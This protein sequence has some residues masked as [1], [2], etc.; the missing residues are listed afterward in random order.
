MEKAK[1]SKEYE[2]GQN[3][4]NLVHQLEEISSNLFRSA[5]SNRPKAHLQSYVDSNFK[6]SKRLYQ[7]IVI[8]QRR[9]R[10]NNFSQI[11]SIY[12]DIRENYH[13]FQKR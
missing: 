7:E 5:I 1:P 10:D 12:K 3:K 2:D 11:N 4:A 8:I 6:S 9:N 13:R